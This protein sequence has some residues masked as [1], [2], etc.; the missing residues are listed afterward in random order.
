MSESLTEGTSDGAA[1]VDPLRR[2]GD[3]RFRVLCE[4]APIGIFLTDAE[5]RDIYRNPRWLALAGMT[6]EEGL[7]EGWAQAVHPE[8]RDALLAD[9]RRTIAAGADWK[10]EHRF[11]TPQGDVRWVAALA[12]PLRGAGGELLGYVGT[13]ED[14]TERKKSE[15]ERRRLERK[16]QEAQKL[17]S[18]GVLAGGVAHDFNN[19]LT[20][21]IGYVS[22][23][24]QQ[25]PDDA[26]LRVFLD[27]AVESA[28]RAAELCQQMLAYSGRG[29]FV[30]GLVDLSQAVRDLNALLKTSV[31]RKAVLSLE[32]AD[33]LPPVLADA[34]QISQG[35][36]NLVLNASESLG[37]REGAVTVRTGLAWCDRDY[38]RHTAVE[39]DLPEGEYLFIEVADTGCGMDDEMRRRVFE[40]FFTTK[41]TGRGLGLAAVL[42]IV[43]GH[44]GAI[45]LTSEPGLGTTAAC[46]CRRPQGRRGGQGRRRRRRRP[47]RRRPGAPCCSW[48]T[49]RPCATWPSGRCGWR[50]SGC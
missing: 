42:G 18:L 5:G 27:R 32:L 23:A 41:F 10:R 16:L 29:R 21:V 28:Q 13:V 25:A 47:P 50:A 12:A 37:G 15:E 17:E 7:G 26:A 38:L 49:S 8:E 33:D 19:L 11:V 22:L 30:V 48:T 40:P 2:L 43:R 31:S 20:G 46:Y 1:E 45:R 24:Q 6:A 14:I 36:L 35:L 4:Q 34:S 3:E 44:H 39:D 9:W